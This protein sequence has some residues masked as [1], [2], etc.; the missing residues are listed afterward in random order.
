MLYHY[1]RLP[2]PEASVLAPV[3]CPVSKG[4]RRAAALRDPGQAGCQ[5]AASQRLSCSEVHAAGSAKAR[6]FPHRAGDM[7]KRA[8]ALG[9]GLHS[10]LPAVLCSTDTHRKIARQED[11]PKCQ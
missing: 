7:R 6:R 3:P 9:R 1:G 5:L 8:A 2:P 4:I 11:R 10:H